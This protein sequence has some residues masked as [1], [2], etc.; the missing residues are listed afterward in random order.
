MCQLTRYK[1]CCDCDRV[2]P[3]DKITRCSEWPRLVSDAQK[4]DAAARERLKDHMRC[5]LSIVPHFHSHSLQRED[6]LIKSYADT[7]NHPVTEVLHVSNVLAGG[8]CVPDERD[9]IVYTP[10]DAELEMSA[11]CPS[12][13]LL[14]TIRAD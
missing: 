1:F 5:K 9:A 14:E 11:M 13:T 10:R 8:T 2:P 7:Q 3:R 4:G 12:L 6:K